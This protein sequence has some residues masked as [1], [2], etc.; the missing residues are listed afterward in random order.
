MDAVRAD[1]KQHAVDII[2]GTIRIIERDDETVLAWARERWACIVFNLHVEH[3]ADGIGKAAA[4]F[5]RL[6]DRALQFGGTYYLT[7]HRWATARQLL[8]GHPRIIEFL[9]EKRQCDPRGVFR[10]DWLTHH[11][12]L[13]GST[14]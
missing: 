6:I 10:S 9:Q 14:S 1:A 4:D 12:R 11:E 8:A 7:Y 3:T 5:R 13:L 2:Y